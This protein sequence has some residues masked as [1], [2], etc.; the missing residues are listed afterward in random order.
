MSP[1][2]EHFQSIRDIFVIHTYEMLKLDK[3]PPIYGVALL[4]AVACEV[5]SKVLPG[6]GRPEDV[7]ARNFAPGAPEHVGRIIYESMRDGLAHSY[8]PHPIIVGSSTVRLALSWK[9]GQHLRVVGLKREGVHNRSVAVERNEA[10]DGP[11]VCVDAEALYR[12]LVAVFDRTRDRLLADP[13][14]ASHV[15]QKAGRV[16]MGDE[17][18]EPKG[19]ALEQWKAFLRSAA[20]HEGDAIQDGSG[21]RDG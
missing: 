2:S 18:K 7:F 16:L 1:P 11:F 21:E 8:G 19:R 4:V 6:A 9:G 5:L 17:R 10:D 20:L 12:D 14:F 13:E 15:E 3:K